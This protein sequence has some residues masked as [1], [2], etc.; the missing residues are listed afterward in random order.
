LTGIIRAPV[1][2]T[3]LYPGI[4]YPADT[5]VVKT[6]VKAFCNLDHICRLGSW[7]LAWLL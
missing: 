6:T 7:T 2:L 5:S 3:I 4:C 1:G